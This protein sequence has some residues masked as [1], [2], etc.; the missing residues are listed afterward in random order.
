[1]ESLFSLKSLFS[2]K[3]IRKNR[4]FRFVCMV[5]NHS[6]L[7]KNYKIELLKCNFN[8]KFEKTPKILKYMDISVAGYAHRDADFPCHMNILQKNNLE[9]LHFRL[10]HK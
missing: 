3:D 10:F 5:R 8:A 7:V 4:K 1:M 6:K 2:G 9:Y